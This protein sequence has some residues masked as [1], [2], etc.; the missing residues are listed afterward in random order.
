ML[1]PI[2][3]LSDSELQIV[4]SAAQP[5]APKDRDPFLKAIAERLATIPERGDGV[6]FQVCRE[7][8]RKHWDPP[9]IEPDPVRGSKE[10]AVISAFYPVRSG[11]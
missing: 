1:M 7:V 5:L 8:Q 10:N 2:V 9:R 4:F 11:R 3:A 6:V